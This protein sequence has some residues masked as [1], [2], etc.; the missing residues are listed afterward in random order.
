MAAYLNF[1]VRVFNTD[2]ITTV[3]QAKEFGRKID[4]AV[5]AFHPSIDMD[6]DV[7]VE[8]V[9]SAGLIDAP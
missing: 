5:R 4:A 1:E 9:E 2:G 6:I 3:E 8:L 7:E